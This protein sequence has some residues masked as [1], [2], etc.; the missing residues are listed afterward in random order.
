MAWRLDSL[1]EHLRGWYTIPLLKFVRWYK[2]KKVRLGVL[3][4]TRVGTR[5]VGLTAGDR[6]GLIWAVIF[7]GRDMVIE[8]KST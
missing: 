6:G 1:L 7:R 4:L 8:L 2:I 3:H 5:L